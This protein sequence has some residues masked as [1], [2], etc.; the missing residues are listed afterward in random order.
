MYFLNVQ[1]LTNAQGTIASLVAP[2]TFDILGFYFY[3]AKYD[4]NCQKQ[5]VIVSDC[6]VGLITSA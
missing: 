1:V 3:I 4:L 5:I 2:Q 6:A